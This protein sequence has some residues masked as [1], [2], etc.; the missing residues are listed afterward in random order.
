VGF[1]TLFLGIGFILSP[2]VAGW[3]ADVT[4]MFMWSFIL[5]ISTAVVSMFLLFLVGKKF[6]FVN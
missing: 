3:I 6:S 2:M 1:W 5:A 4:G